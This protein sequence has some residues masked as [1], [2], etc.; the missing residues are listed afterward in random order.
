VLYPPPLSPET[1]PAE[2]YLLAS[3]MPMDGTWVQLD[4]VN[5][6]AAPTTL[7]QHRQISEW[8]L[9]MHTE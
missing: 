1:A 7:S 5:T 6:T 3:T 2:W 9:R 8:Q 4:Y